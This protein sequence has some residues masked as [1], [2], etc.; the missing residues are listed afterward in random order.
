LTLSIQIDNLTKIFDNQIVV[1][2]LKFEV[3]NGEI[4]VFVGPNGVGKST[5]IKILATLLKSDDGT[6]SINGYDIV[7][8]YLEVKKSKKLSL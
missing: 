1:D 4:E 2:H 8:D 3:K 5:T 7:K 6:A